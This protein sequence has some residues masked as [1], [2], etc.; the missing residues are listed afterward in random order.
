MTTTAQ[1]VF[2]DGGR[3]V[4]S[5]AIDLDDGA[6]QQAL[7]VSRL[8][9]V[10]GH[11][12]LMPDAH[13][14]YGMPVGGVF[15]ADSAIVPY[16]IGV[17]IGCGVSLIQTGRPAEKLT[18]AEVR[19]FLGQVARDIPVGNGPQAQ[20]R[21]QGDP[22]S[23]WIGASDRVS[24]F[25]EAAEVQLG[26]LGGGNHFLELQRGDD[27]GMLYFMIHS[28]SRSLGK[29]TCD[30]HHKRALALD[31]MWHSALP[32]DEVAWL[33]FR[34]QE[35]A[36]YF[37]DMD[38]VLQWAEENRK[39]MA[40]KVI[41]AFSTVLGIEAA[42][43]HDIHHNYAAWEQ[44]GGKNGIVHRKGAVRAREGERVLVPGSMSTGSYIAEGLGNPESFSTCQHGAGRARSRAATRKML[45]LEQMDQMLV[46]AGV[47]LVTPKRA[48]VID[49]AAL[50]YKDIESVMAASADLV[51]PVQRLS[52][53]GVVKG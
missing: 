11:V 21:T 8:P 30:L 32:H 18:P 10:M 24:A 28:G 15:M 31:R 46:D 7:N 4:R 51:R 22:V 43:T 13:Q 25:V 9:F 23:P 34:S 19:R 37:D 38:T 45:S 40:V 20:H 14:G 17:D 16:A 48:D 5:W 1:E 2:Q 3:P 49:E 6:R 33:P 53:I 41:E 39:R 36:E 50:A 47:Q 44:H 35:G 52:P 27:D 29:K 42:M 26:T 12:A